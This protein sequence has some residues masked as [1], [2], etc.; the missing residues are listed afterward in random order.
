[1]YMCIHSN[2]AKLPPKTTLCMYIHMEYIHANALRSTELEQAK[3]LVVW[4]H[5]YARYGVQNPSRLF[6]PGTEVLAFA[7]AAWLWNATLFLFLARRISHHRT[8]SN[9]PIGHWAE[10]EAKNRLRC[11]IV[12]TLEDGEIYLVEVWRLPVRPKELDPLNFC[13]WQL[14]TMV[15][16]DLIG[17]RSKVLCTLCR[18]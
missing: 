8:I 11:S 3:R 13:V 6:L 18:S 4:M 5:I 1:M 10:R 15:A 17:G 12:L 7:G 16:Q 14:G 9:Y 2:W